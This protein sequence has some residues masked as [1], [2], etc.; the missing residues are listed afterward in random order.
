MS[1]SGLGSGL[2]W[3]TLINQIVDIERE[4]IRN[5]EA[6]R[7]GINQKK[8]IWSDIATKLS[9]LKASIDRIS[10]RNAFEPKKTSYT[11]ADVVEISPSWEAESLTYSITV[12]RLARS[13][14]IKSENLQDPASPLGLSGTFY[15]NGNSVNVDAS[16]TLLSIRDKIDQ[17]AGDSLNAQVIDGTLVLKSVDSGALNAISL[18]DDETTHCL[19]SLGFLDSAGNIKNTVQE[20]ADS[21][22]II[23]GVTVKRDSNL[24]ND[25]IPSVTLKLLKEGPQAS[26][27]VSISRDVAAITARIKEFVDAYNHVISTLNK[28]GGKNGSL[29]GDYGITIVSGQIR[30][31]ATDLIGQSDYRSLWQIG[32]WTSG[33]DGLLEIDEGKL[34]E[35]LEKDPSMVK[36]LF[37]IGGETGTQGVG[38]RLSETIKD[39]TSYPDGLVYARGRALS[40]MMTDIDK[41]V[42]QIEYRLDRR[43][44][45][46]MRQ[47]TAME[48][49]LTQLQQQSFWLLADK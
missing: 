49:A 2:D 37:F 36:D 40:N 30:R 11:L 19:K 39:L 26:T 15:V 6:R 25:A 20:A 33:E 43:E 44:E 3:R 4:P 7:Q 35:G 8:S 14:I 48:A 29:Q 23:D 31:G 32:I 24:I 16:D 21:E 10:E 18:T 12:N 38:E 41:R 27:E 13:H 34:K 42:E 1:V 47:F 28:A 22:V 46:L 17:A 9:V 5:L 45:Y